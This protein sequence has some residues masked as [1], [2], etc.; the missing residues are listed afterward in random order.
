MKL[1]LR[2][3]Q[4][5]YATVFS[6]FLVCLGIGLIIPVMPFLKNHLGLSALE[7]GIMSSLFALTQFIISPVVGFLSDRVGR[8]VVI[9]LGLALFGVSELIF[10]M[11]NQLEWFYFSRIIGGMSAAMSVPTSMALAADLTTPQQRAKVIGWLSAAFSGGLILGPG[12]GGLLAQGGDKVPFWIAGGLGM[13]SAGFMFKVLPRTS[14]LPLQVHQAQTSETKSAVN[15]RAIVTRSFIIL[16]LLILVSSFGLQGFESIYSLYVNEVFGFSMANIA[17]VL[18][19]N[20]LCSL[21]LQVVCFEPLVAWLGEKRLITLCFGLTFLGTL[22]ILKAHQQWEVI[23]ATLVVFSAIDVVRP[24]IT[25]LLTKASP[26]HQGLIN[27]LNMSLTS[28]GNV[29]GPLMSGW[30]LDVNTHY[31]YTVVA[32][33]MAISIVLALWLERTSVARIRRTH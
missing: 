5:I 3:R 14:E 4:I 13:L 19:L 25:T 2:V 7:M 33:F 17:F 22:W 29:I 32:G 11:T 6:E 15:W 27:G 28:L 18:T 20:G 12:L 24:A 9:V 21:L 31:P 26:T 10:A 16:C 23:V 8:K 30:L 1:T